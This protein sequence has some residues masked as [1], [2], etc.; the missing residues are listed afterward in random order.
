MWSSYSPLEF[1]NP[2]PTRSASGSV[3]K[4]KSALTS[5]AN[6]IAFTYASGDSGFGVIV[7]LKSGSVVHCSKTGNS[8]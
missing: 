8:S 3:V 6:S 7:A 4:I 5:L 2:T 1:K